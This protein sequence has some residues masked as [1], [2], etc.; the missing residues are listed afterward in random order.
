MICY[1]HADPR[2]PFLVES[3]DQPAARWNDTGEGPVQYLSDT[4]DGAWAEFLRHEEITDPA[5]LATVRRALWAVEVPEERWVAPDLPTQVMTGGPSTYP[6]C[7]AAAREARAAGAPGLV[8]PS[9]ALM[10]GAAHGWRVDRGLVPGPAR[11]G[12]TIV[13]FG[14]RPGLVAWAAVAE[15]RPRD[16]LL[17]LVRHLRRRR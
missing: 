14:P 8:A 4:P 5:D 10:P 2:L 3:A 6:A 9:A 7:R 11:D 15:G 13:L 1:R 12:R 17:R 16:D